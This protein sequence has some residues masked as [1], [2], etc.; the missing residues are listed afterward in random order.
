M[1]RENDP[2]M[3][4]FNETVYKFT[5]SR[6]VFLKAEQVPLSSILP[7]IIASIITW[8]KH[9]LFA[10]LLIPSLACWTGRC[11]ARMT[12]NVTRLPRWKVWDD[13]STFLFEEQEGFFFCFFYILASLM[14]V[15]FLFLSA[16]ERLVTSIIRNTENETRNSGQSG[17][18][19]SVVLEAACSLLTCVVAIWHSSFIYLLLI[20][21]IQFSSLC[22]S[23]AWN[24]FALIDHA[25]SP[26]QT[27]RFRGNHF[28]LAH[29]LFRCWN[30][31]QARDLQVA[32]KNTL[33]LLY[34][35]SFTMTFPES[36]SCFPRFT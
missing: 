1:Y 17:T 11:W 6:V 36:K 20:I 12:G 19:V 21:A 29:R 10:H 18:T 24:I 4:V 7:P 32:I 33:T 27:V 31:S 8:L 28:A 14:S 15:F 9:H 34:D 5:Q 26:V 16:E 35:C 23:A 25:A 22:L 2:G 3:F 13:S 30:A